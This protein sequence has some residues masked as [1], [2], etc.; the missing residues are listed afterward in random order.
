ME[1]IKEQD[2]AQLNV[3]QSL[4]DQVF[5]VAPL[6]IVGTREGEKYDLAPKH[7]VT[8]LGF[9]PYFGF[10][11]TPRHN[12]FHNIVATGEFTVSFPK[13]DQLVFTSLSATPRNDSC[14]KSDVV[15][16]ALPVAK[17]LNMDVPVIE[18]AYLYL[19]CRSIKILDG[20]D[21]YA[22]I[23]GEVVAAYADEDYALGSERDEQDQLQEN[24]LLVYVAPG[25]FARISQTFNFPFPKDF[26]R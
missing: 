5:T 21:D 17:A 12:T 1:R 25:R 22:I 15:L 10:V 7:M 23:T 13:P 2:F 11:C 20:F 9:G 19:E 16:D 8:P 18:G 24:P 26:K 14:S 6:V 4:L 3:K